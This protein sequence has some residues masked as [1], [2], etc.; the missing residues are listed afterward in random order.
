MNSQLKLGDRVNDCEGLSN[1]Q[2]NLEALNVLFLRYR[3]TLLFVAY[4]VLGDHNQ[5]EDAVQRCLQSAAYRNVP[6]FENEGAF[7]SWL[8]RVL[9]DVAL[10]ILQEREWASRIVRTDLARIYPIDPEF[11]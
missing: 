3:R 5:A 6:R 9:I 2:G 7:R 10:F 11:V 8:V 4:R 1:S